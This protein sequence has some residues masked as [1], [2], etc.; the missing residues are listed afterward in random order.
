MISAPEK[1]EAGVLLTVTAPPALHSSND[2]NN[3]NNDILEIRSNENPDILAERQ[4]EPQIPLATV[5]DVDDEM[6][7]AVSIRNHMPSADCGK[8]DEGGDNNILPPSIASNNDE[9]LIQVE[10][11]SSVSDDYDD[12]DDDESSSSSSSSSSNSSTDSSKITSLD[13]ET[14]LHGNKDKKSVVNNLGLKEDNNSNNNSSNNDEAEDSAVLT[15][16]Q[17]FHR[18]Y[19][20]AD[21]MGM[22]F[23]SAYND[24]VRQPTSSVQRKMNQ[25]QQQQ[26]PDEKKRM[27]RRNMQMMQM[28]LEMGQD[29]AS[30]RRMVGQRLQLRR[31]GGGGGGIR[32]PSMNIHGE[33]G[34]DG[35][36]NYDVNDKDPYSL[37]GGRRQLYQDY[38]SGLEDINSREIAARGG[39]GWSNPR[40]RRM[41]YA[42]LAVIIGIVLIVCTVLGVE[43]DA[44]YRSNNNNNNNN[45][46]SNS[47]SN[48]DGEVPSNN[49]H[50][51]IPSSS[52][53][54]GHETLL[55]VLKESYSYALLGFTSS[56]M[57]LNLVEKKW[58]NRNVNTDAA[59]DDQSPQWRAYLHL[60][61]I[62]Y[63]DDGGGGEEDNTIGK[64]LHPINDAERLLQVYALC[65]FYETFHWY[66]YKDSDNMADF[67]F[68]CHWPGVTCSSSSSSSSSSEDEGRY[69]YMRVLELNA[70][71]S[72]S[73]G[74]GATLLRGEL[75]IELVFLQH[76][77]TLDISHNLIEGR[78]DYVG[79]IFKKLMNLRQ[80][81]LNDNKFVSSFR[82]DKSLS[83]YVFH[84][85]ECFMSHTMR[86]LLH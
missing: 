9:G 72:G 2:N 34:Y 77:E 8:D 32:K 81:D 47:Q 35:D 30:V 29:R 44:Q 69:D 33:E 12:D 75:P 56:D 73:N 55:V 4:Q 74:G 36:Y 86:C 42:L 70:R 23:Y 24:V 41:C 31:G 37:E 85:V 21:V 10:D 15:K 45:N 63:S 57:I 1:V 59:N 14:P 49:S 71:G 50:D 28:Q 26:Q 68:E 61:S 6:H 53:S 62:I 25:K 18:S 19:D 65:V 67:Y 40:K 84:R 66:A 48:Y 80:L 3:N 82:L 20:E 64:S 52:S 58:L 16:N 43:K 76:L 27:R 5:V 51:S 22:E 46:N 13:D 78:G 39:M 54:Y 38:E 17:V 79:S 7:A 11:C 60:S 83:I